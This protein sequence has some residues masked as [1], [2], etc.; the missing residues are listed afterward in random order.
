[1]KIDFS[2]APELL[3]KLEKKAKEEFRSVNS[4]ILYLIRRGLDG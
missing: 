3:D 2:N 4:Q 1:M